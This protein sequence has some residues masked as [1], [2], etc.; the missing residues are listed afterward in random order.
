MKKTK[1]P[2]PP[3]VRRVQKAA[4]TPTDVATFARIMSVIVS[5]YSRGETNLHAVQVFASLGWSDGARE[6]YGFQSVG[7]W[8]EEGKKLRS[9]VLAMPESYDRTCCLAIL[10]GRTPEDF[11]AWSK[12]HAR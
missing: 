8:Q 10:D 4:G 9:V 6:E 11:D 2:P 12:K 5:L 3:G 1:K 7:S